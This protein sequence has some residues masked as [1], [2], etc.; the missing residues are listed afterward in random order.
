ME[1]PGSSNELTQV[2]RNY[3]HTSKTGFRDRH[4]TDNLWL[5]PLGHQ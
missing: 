2:P 4:Q 5:T 3:L 1:K